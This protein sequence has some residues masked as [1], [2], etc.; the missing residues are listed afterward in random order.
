MKEINCTVEVGAVLQFSYEGDITP[1]I[2]QQL[3]L[4]PREYNTVV[5]REFTWLICKDEDKELLEEDNSHIRNIEH[6]GIRT[7]KHNDEI[8]TMTAEEIQEYYS[9]S[10]IIDITT[11]NYFSI[12]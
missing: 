3:I 11:K 7:Y 9:D 5:D 12:D 2:L 1:D 10:P 8:D 6:Q 4:L